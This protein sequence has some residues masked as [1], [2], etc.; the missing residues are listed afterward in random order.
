MLAV[1]LRV[2]FV[3]TD[4]DC[5]LVGVLKPMQTICQKGLPRDKSWNYL[6]LEYP[7]INRGSTEGMKPQLVGK[8]DTP[9]FLI[10]LD[11]GIGDAVA[12]GLSAVDQIIRN[13]PTANGA[14][15]VLCNQLQTEVF[16]YDPRINRI[17][18]T[19]ITFFPSCD[20]TTWYKAIRLD[21]KAT[22]VV[23]FLRDRHYEAVLPSIVAPAF[24]MGLGSHIMYPNLLMLWNNYFALHKQE[25]KSLTRVIREMVNRS[26]ANKLSELTHD[27]SGPYEE[28]L[29][30]IGSEQ[31]QK[32]RTVVAAMKERSSVSGEDSKL[33]V[34][35]PDTASIVTRPPT[36]LLAA[37]LAEALALKSGRDLIVCIL[38]SYSEKT[39][40]EKLWR[41]LAL[42]FDG[43]VF[44]LSAEPRA[45]LSETTAF[46]D[47]ADIFVTGDT[48]LMHLA[49]ATKTVRPGEDIHYP[50]RNTVKIISL[51]GGTNPGYYGYLQRTTILGWGRK[52]QTAFRPGIAKEGYDPRG[53]SLFDHISP[54][55]LT[56][57]IISSGHIEIE[58]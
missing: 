47:Q 56:E 13:D 43:R 55:Q 26:F 15:D 52:E 30:Y 19:D 16:T 29:L 10:T 4:V 39:S 45:S 37:A 12:V 31:I 36:N 5:R 8:P 35:A 53:R 11:C 42:A 14:I 18:Q 22:A 50:P 46:I 3:V 25:L 51:F 6:M 40:S 54:Q 33:L 57:A 28:V 24:Y 48:G 2:T 41:A 58:Q 49:A 32:A 21:A 38:P 34:V 20:V 44:L 17:I 23:G 1:E 9:R 27:K 7:A